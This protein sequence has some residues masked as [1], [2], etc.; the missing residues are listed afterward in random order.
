MHT[1][2]RDLPQVHDSLGEALYQLRLKGALYCQS[3][4]TAPWGID[5]PAMADKML[6]HIVLSGR[7]WL[8]AQGQAP[9]ELTAGSLA[10][11]PKGQG[12]A[13]RSE[14]NT[15]VIHLFDIPINQVSERYELMRYGGGGDLTVLAC[16]VIGFDHL[17]GAKLI[18]HLPSMIHLPAQAAGG[19]GQLATTLQ[20]LA[21][22]AAHLTVGSETVVAHLADIIVIQALRYWLQTAPEAEKGWL[23]ALKDP[24]LGKALTA[25]HGQPSAPWT[26]DLLAN[27]AG[28]SR[29][30]FAARFTELLGVSVKQYV[31]EWR[32][33]LARVRLRTD[34]IPLGQLAEEL[35]Y[36]SEAAFS[37]A[38][39]R[40][41]GE[42]P[43]RHSAQ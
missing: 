17:S 3:E 27:L 16:G 25:I 34:A 18:G 1:Y 8:T 24:K 11:L 5:M 14:R 31:T 39:K 6:F 4:L 19:Q 22:E 23:G 36:Q 29:S 21:T 32:M 15:P 20:L 43:V 28:M 37:R 7:C 33:S 40:V 10:L 2:T 35:G 42:S 12:H 41:M 38:Y 30:S 9:I 13:I 26:V